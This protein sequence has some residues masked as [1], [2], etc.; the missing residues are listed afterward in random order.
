MNLQD[1]NRLAAN[2]GLA[3]AGEVVSSGDW[4]ALASA[5]P[6]PVGAACVLL[7]A[8]G[9]RRAHAREESSIPTRTWE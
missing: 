2:F 4:S 5:V 6:E 8:L 3:A 7:L 9:A 1:F